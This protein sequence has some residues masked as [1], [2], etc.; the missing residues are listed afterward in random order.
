M[1]PAGFSSAG[2]CSGRAK[3]HLDIQMPLMGG[4]QAAHSIREIKAGR[5]RGGNSNPIP[6]TIVA[7]S[8][9]GHFENSDR[10]GFAAI[11]Y[12]LPKPVSFADVQGLLASLQIADCT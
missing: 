2:D 6:V 9:P 3:H 11:S 8:A 10:L 7:V 5:M 4:C 1:R 12:C